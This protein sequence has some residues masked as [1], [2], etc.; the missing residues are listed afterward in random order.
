MMQSTQRNSMFTAWGWFPAWCGPQPGDSVGYEVV[1]SWC[2]GNHE[3][4]RI[5]SVALLHV[6]RGGPPGFSPGSELRGGG[7]ETVTSCNAF[8]MCVCSI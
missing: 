8:P 3:I 7:E 4:C 5:V 6:F 1:S 2:R